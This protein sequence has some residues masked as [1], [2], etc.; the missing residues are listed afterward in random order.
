MTMFQQ[1]LSNSLSIQ[2]KVIYQANQFQQG[3]FE[4]IIKIGRDIIED[5]LLKPLKDIPN[6]VK[7]IQDCQDHCIDYWKNNSNL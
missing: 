2:K 6:G 7:T 1:T 3:L 4:E 5:K